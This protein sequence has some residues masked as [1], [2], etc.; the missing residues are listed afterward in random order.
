MVIVRFKKLCVVEVIFD[1]LNEVFVVVK[2]EVEFFVEY[3]C[4]CGCFR[5][6][7]VLE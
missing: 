1:G 2:G 4:L 5:K 6:V 3:K 7:G